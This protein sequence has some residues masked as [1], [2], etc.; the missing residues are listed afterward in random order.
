MRPRVPLGH[1]PTPLEPLRELAT[2]LGASGLFVKRDD[3]TGFAMGG[4]K[5]RQLEYQLAGALESRATIV[6]ATGAV[7]SNFLR[8][9][10]AATARL[11]LDFEALLEDRV[12]GR[13]S[14]YYQT[15]NVLLD[16]LFGARTRVVPNGASEAEA[17][18]HVQ[19]R[20]AEL[21]A[22]GSVPYVLSTAEE[23]PPLGALGY[24]DAA[25]ELSDQVDAAGIDVSRLVVATGTGYTQAGLLVGLRAA[26]RPDIAVTGVAVRRSADAQ[27]R[28]VLRLCEALEELTGTRARVSRDDVL[29]TDDY[30]EPAYG[31]VSERVRRAVHM[32]A[33]TEG[34]LLD[35][36]YTGRAFAGFL[37]L[38]EQ[39]RG[40]VF[41]HTG[42]TPA[43]FA[44]PEIV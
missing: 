13:D 30:L 9:A 3:C 15:G 6:L 17:E 18:R 41:V 25:L 22:A 44:Y 24:V 21:R 1:A 40:V 39:E 12:S 19:A 23:A 43:L 34:L 42:G 11:D 38:S 8:C 36:V 16:R 2:H 10:A 28:R 7:Q 29:V 31:Q 14:D 37:D 5:V 35:P 33:R 26:G 27:C 4:N 20:A 32:A